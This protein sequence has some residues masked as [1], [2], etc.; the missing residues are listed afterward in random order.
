MDDRS[1]LWAF[2]G[3]REDVVKIAQSLLSN[4]IE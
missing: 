3:A 4:E 2:R 1:Q